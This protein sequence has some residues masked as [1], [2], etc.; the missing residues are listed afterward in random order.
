MQAIPRMGT[1]TRTTNRSDSRIQRPHSFIQVVI[2]S[3]G[4]A[5]AAWELDPVTWPDFTPDHNLFACYLSCFALAG[6]LAEK[7]TAMTAVDR[8]IRNLG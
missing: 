3:V 4:C 7:I 5:V 8:T 2:G 6:L 1:V